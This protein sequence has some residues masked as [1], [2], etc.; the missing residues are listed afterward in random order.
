MVYRMDLGETECKENEKIAE[1]KVA[2][3]SII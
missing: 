3:E 1:V 2:D